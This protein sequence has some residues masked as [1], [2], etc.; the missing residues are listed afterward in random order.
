MKIRRL[1]PEEYAELVDL[2]ENA[3]LPYRPR[4]R[5]SQDRIACEAESDCTFFLVAEETGTLI[6]SVL[7]THDGRKG[8]INR[9]AVRP[10]FRNQGIARALV[11]EVEARLLDRGIE[12][13]CC[14]IEGWNEGSMAFFE[15]IGYLGHENVTYY[16]K[17]RSEDT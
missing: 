14:L 4:G 9:L 7:G 8:W 10:G 13:V 3:G 6:G 16:S 5:D 12:I 2:W 15:R 11:A 17:R 1:K